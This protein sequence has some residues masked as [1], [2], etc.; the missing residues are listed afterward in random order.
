[1]A[2]GVILLKCPK[3]DLNYRKNHT[4]CL[5]GIAPSLTKL[6]SA[7]KTPRGIARYPRFG[8]MMFTPVSEVAAAIFGSIPKPAS[9]AV[10]A[11]VCCLQRVSCP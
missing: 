2:E 9:P 7:H 3:Q 4:D 11:A 8:P 1:M 10:I 6:P 5:H